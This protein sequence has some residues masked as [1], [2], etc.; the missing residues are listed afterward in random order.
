MRTTGHRY[1]STFLEILVFHRLTLLME[2]A[3]HIQIAWA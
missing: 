1:V 2:N 3:L